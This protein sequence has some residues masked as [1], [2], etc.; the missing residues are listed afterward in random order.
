[1]NI[2]TTTPDALRHADV[3]EEMAR[4]KGLFGAISAASLLRAI[5]T[6]RDDLRYEIAEMKRE[7]ANR[8]GMLELVKQRRDELE[9]EVEKLR[10]GECICTRCGL[11]QPGEDAGPVPF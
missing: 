1:M 2:P 6:E 9:A 8:G 7:F 10:R 3:L 4:A 11:R 5:S